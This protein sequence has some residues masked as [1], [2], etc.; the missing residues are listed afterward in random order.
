MNTV[1]RLRLQNID[2]G[3]ARVFFVNSQAGSGVDK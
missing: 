2:T 1:C 3:E